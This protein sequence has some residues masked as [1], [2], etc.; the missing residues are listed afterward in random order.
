[1]LGVRTMKLLT[2]NPVKRGGI[3][4]YGLTIKERVPLVVTP[5]EHN[6]HYL[7]TKAARLGHRYHPDPG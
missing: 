3:E 2:N 4:G 6:R 5:N 1:D 7:E